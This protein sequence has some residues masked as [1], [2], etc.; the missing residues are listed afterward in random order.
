MNLK[1]ALIDEI[2]RC[3]NNPYTKDELNSIRFFYIQDIHDTLMLSY[4]QPIEKYNL[5]LIK[6]IEFD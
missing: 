4:G 2:L 5:D 3:K 6:E 1:Q